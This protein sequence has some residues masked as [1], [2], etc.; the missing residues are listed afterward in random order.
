MK[1]FIYT[2]SEARISLLVLC[3]LV[4]SIA[5]RIFVKFYKPNKSSY[6]TELYA[7]VKII[8]D[9]L[10]LSKAKQPLDSR[11]RER[12]IRDFDPNLADSSALIQLGFTGFTVN[13]IMKYRNSG[14]TFK[15]K[16]DLLKIYGMNDSIYSELKDYI[17]IEAVKHYNGPVSIGT[18]QERE[19]LGTIQ[20]RESL[21]TIQEKA[22]IKLC[23]NTADSAGLAG[24][25]GMERLS[26]RIVK[27]RNVL[28]GFVSESQL[29]DVYG[30]DTFLLNRLLLYTFID[31]SK[32]RRFD[33]NDVSEWELTRHPYINDICAHD[34]IKYREISGRINN[35][36]ELL[37]NGIL[38]DSLFRKIKPY[39][40]CVNS[41]ES[42]LAQ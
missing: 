21:G 23:I 24:I 6:N 28:G 32:I 10:E 18:I 9:S 29:M 16:R 34:I 12:I 8:I 17:K 22:L 41:A 11:N 2:R 31:S 14:G 19:S 37:D 1:Y 27:Y 39:I 13:N 42:S 4:A 38:N 15:D 26:S 36:Y 3:L 35:S 25:P 20:E 7:H 5:F 40:F 33:L 30:M